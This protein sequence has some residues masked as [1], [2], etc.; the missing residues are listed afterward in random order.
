MP[1]DQ[2][3]H[4]STC[5]E[6][7]VSVDVTK[8][9]VAVLQAIW[10]TEERY[11]VTMITDIVCGNRTERI[12]KFRL[13]R[14][15]VFGHLNRWAD[16]DVKGFIKRLIAMGFLTS[17]GGQ[18]PILSVTEQGHDV[19]AGCIPVKDVPIEVGEHR[20]L[21]KRGK[22]AVPGLVKATKDNSLFEALRIHRLALSKSEGVKPF[23][24]FS[25]ATLLD[26]VAKEPLTLGDMAN[27]K[28]V[29]D[30]KLRKYG[31]E[32]LKVIAEFKGRM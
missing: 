25:D 26:M 18:Y 13:H 14:L 27:V 1:W 31:N 11:G 15:P 16:K 4:C 24:I 10:N 8:E 12:E 7:R 22:P 20:P 19:L 3:H 2:C 29:G 21:Q 28:G 6:P 9:A 23:M 30:M 17:S 5:D 32:F